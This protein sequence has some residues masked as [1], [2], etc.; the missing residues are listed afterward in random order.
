M[1]L[2]DFDR[3]AAHH[4]FVQQ[5]W[6]HLHDAVTAEFLGQ[7]RADIAAVMQD[8][9]VVG[10]NRANKDQFRYELAE[11]QAAQQELF[12]VICA[13]TSLSSESIVLSER[14]VNAYHQRADDDPVPH[15]D[16]FASAI[17]VGLSIDVAPES[18]LVLYP[19]DDRSL[20]TCDSAADYF[21]GLE[22]EQ[23]PPAVLKENRLAV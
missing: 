11:P 18:S 12:D 2:F 4:C 8:A 19:Y 21:A 20:N 1:R 5:G 7:V 22:P 15:K 6:V 13:V 17:S 10:G 3:D 16:R 23:R 14:H 9:E